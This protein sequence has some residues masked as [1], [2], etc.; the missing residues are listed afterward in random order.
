MA[1]QPLTFL[2][3]GASSGFGLSLSLHA[4]RNGH[5]VVATVRTR[6]GGRHA[7]AVQA[8]EEL[9]GKCVELD[10]SDLAAIPAVVASVLDGGRGKIDVLV[11]NAGYSLLGAVEDMTIEETKAQMETNF[12][13]PLRLIQAV[14]PHMRARRSGT[15]VNVSSVAGLFALPSCG[16]YS[17][18]KFALEGKCRCPS[19]LPRTCLS[20]SLAKELS[21]FNIDVLIVEPGA[22]RTNFLASGVHTEKPLSEAYADASSPLTQTLNRLADYQAQGPPGDTDKGA[23]VIYE[24]A[25]GNA[26]GE[27]NGEAGELKGKLLRLLLGKDAVKR[28]EAKIGSLQADLE[29]MRGVASGTDA[30]DARVFI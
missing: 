29:K 19:A 1:S 16:L 18:S 2:I 12:F 24:V 6:T 26:S 23:R 4:L 28:M 8:I 3:T 13:G 14:V 9:G 5:N 7:S 21:P 11:N 15:I 30:H 27:K 22:F 17:A 25:V 20:E 10:V